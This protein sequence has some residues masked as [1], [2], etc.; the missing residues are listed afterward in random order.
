MVNT[1]LFSN[2]LKG[3]G[4]EY[5][6]EVFSTIEGI[7]KWFYNIKINKELLST[8]LEELKAQPNSVFDL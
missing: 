3:A 7:V 2:I 4:P 1:I 8:T 6:P 5:E